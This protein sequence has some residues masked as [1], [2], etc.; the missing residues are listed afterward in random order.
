M[1]YLK[2]LTCVIL[3]LITFSISTLALSVDF[4]A[5]DS[6]GGAGEAI[7]ITV[8]ITDINGTPLNN[9]RVNFTTDLGILNSSYM[10]TNLSGFA[11]VTINSTSTG[12]AHINA[13]SGSAYNLTNITFLPSE[14]SAILVNSD[15]SV[16]TAGNI[17]NITFFAVDIFGN[18]NSSEIINL[19]II[20]RDLLGNTLPEIDLSL[21]TGN[22]TRLDVNR[23]NS[24][25]TDTGVL[26]GSVIL[27]FNSTVAGNTSINCTAGAISN[28]TSLEIIPG[29]PGL[30]KVVYNDDHTVNTSSSFYVSVFDRYENPVE[31]VN[32]TFNVTS[33]GNTIYNSPLTYNSASIDVN[34]GTTD[35]TGKI[36]NI[37][38]TDKRAGDNIVSISV[39]NTSLNHNIT[40]TGLADEIENLFLSYT[41]E[42]AIANNQESYVLSA[43]SIDQFMNPVLPLT[44]PIKEQVRFTTDSGNL[45]LVPLNS[46]GSTNTVVGP[47]PYIESLSVTATYRNESGYTNFTNSTTLSF[48]AGSLAAMD[49]YSVPNTVLAQGLN[50]NHESTITFVALDEWGHSLSNI[51]VTLNNTNTTV[52]TFSVDGINSTDQINATTD[53]EGRIYGMFTGN[54][55]GNTSI[56]AISDNISMSTNVNVKDEPFLSVNLS[57]QPSTVSSGS[58]VNVT[59]VISVEG[60]LPLTRPAASA[61]LVLDRSGSMDPD[62][63]AGTPLDVVLVLDRSGSMAGPYLADAKT[64]A[65]DFADNLVSNSEVGVV[66]F[67]DSS[68]VDLGMTL[69]NS[70]GNKTPVHNAIDS[71]E[72]GGYTAM[73]EGMGDANDLLVNYGRSGT[74]K[75]MIVLTD[76]E[77][78]TGDDQDGEDAIDFAND[79]AITIYTIGLGSSLDEALLRHIASETRGAYY[80]APDSSDLSEIYNTIAQELSDYDVSDIEYGVEGFTP[81]DYTFDESLF[82]L[83]SDYFEDS[84]FINETINDLKVQLDWENSINNLSLQLTSPSGNVYGLN[85]DT[86][87][88][89]PNGNSSEYIWIQPLS[90]LYPDN[91]DDTVETGNWTVSVTGSGTGTVDFTIKTYIDKKSA[92]KLSSHA[93]VSSFDESRGDKAGLALYSFEDVVSSAN[94]TSYILDNSTWVGYFTAETEGFYN[95]NVS[96]NDSSLM[97][98][99]LYDGIDIVSSSNGTGVCEV[100]YMLSADES[101]YVEIIKGAGAVTDTQFTINVSTTDVGTVIT[102]YYD[103]SGGGGTPKFRTWNGLEWSGEQSANYVGGI[104]Y[105]VVLESNP[106]SSEIIMGTSDHNYDVNV[107]IWDGSS[108]DGVNQFTSHL[109][110]YSRRGFDVKYEQAS[111]DAII[112]YMDMDINDGVPR[113]SVWDG[114]S[115]SS[116]AAVDSSSPGSG[117]IGWIE[118]ESNPNSDEM[119]LVTLDDKSDIRAQVWDGSSWGNAEFITNDARATSYQCFDV[120]YEQGTGRAIVTWA[121]AGTGDVRYRIWDGSSW[122]SA[123]N[124][125]T[126]DGRVYWI[127]MA[128]DPNSNDILL[129]TLDNNYDIHVIAWNGSAWLSPEEIETDVYEYSRR[130]VDVA[131]E[132]SSGTGMVVWGSSNSVPRYRTWDGSSWSST[133]Y[134]S[135]LGGSGYTRWVQLTPDPDTDDIFLMTSDG[136]DDLNIQK[137]DGSSWSIVTEAETSSTRYYECFDIVFNDVDTLA[138]STPVSWNEWTA[139]V[140]ST[141]DNDSLSHLENAIDTI[142]ADGLTAID[143][144]LFVANNELSSEIGNSTIVIMTDGMD[145]AGYHSLLEESYKAKDNNTVIYTVGFGNNE[146]EIDPMLG[147]IANITGGEYYFAPNSSVLKEIFRG[148]ASQITNFSADGPVLDIHVPYNYVTPLSVAKAT[149]ISGSSNATT[150]NITVFDYPTAPATGNAEPTITTGSGMSIL[151]WQLPS[152]GTGDK[153]GIWY[154]MRV[155][156][157]G[158][159]PLIFPTSTITYTDLS[160][161]NITVYVPSGGSASIGGDGASVLSYSLGSLNLDS[162]RSILPIASKANIRLTLADTTGNSSFAYV[163]LYSS[164]GYFDNYENPIN[165][166]V[167]GSDSVEFSSIT[168]GKA[169]IT[170]YAYNVNNASD[171]LVSKDV[172]VVRPRGTINIR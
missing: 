8:L 142:T 18:V 132:Q 164:I 101:Y 38:T 113:Y 151:E 60:E 165:I 130:S 53:S 147:E 109:D 122:S 25:I 47:T 114:S 112:V 10:S 56:V 23:T 118:L 131:F 42:H 96:W 22:I 80:N 166:T 63:Y 126:P 98:V 24:V 171:V 90:Y 40:I 144:G 149:Y 29:S 2:K 83:S 17:T 81:Y 154:Q 169:Y 39:V 48:I 11:Q 36:S 26:S 103:S 3:V 106:L 71:L 100:S 158:Y 146:S 161:E 153:W 35:T 58:L 116:G 6:Q 51:N 167:V 155:D 133:S 28:I 34:N 75:V 57:I 69:M 136:N 135:D 121:D 62:Y 156:G 139:S 119:V 150:G 128:S 157:A 117:D 61:I 74:R 44:T 76:G 33:P 162:D 43:R 160:G 50:G 125:Y 84:F 85:D 27:N 77:T 1:G 46:Q 105:Y 68:R 110:S 104:P 93:F 15:H 49:L 82:D 140:T 19:N 124:L 123:T 95:F 5:M 12:V 168:A 91:D 54:I 143:E 59:T 87:G 55:S 41:P 137:W 4:M 115:W 120:S 97:D 129:A 102:A 52:G 13:S 89:Y 78:N 65:K 99:Y 73:G 134:A 88:Y 32:V 145:N 20:L 31:N 79:N 159:V 138:E 16:N 170:A 111:G 86:T 37:F 172:L 70:Y 148:I 127:K 94:Q 92:A 152:M 30:M 107:Q 14:T 163:H 7:N 67:S 72:D 21:S 141:L 45:V 64:A 66:S 108:W 9:T